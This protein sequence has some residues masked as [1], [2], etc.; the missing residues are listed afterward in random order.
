MSDHAKEVSKL[1]CDYQIEKAK[2]PSQIH[3]VKSVFQK[4]KGI[5]T[6]G[7]SKAMLARQLAALF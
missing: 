2:A 3:T 5:V 1:Y 7:L 4:P 6:T